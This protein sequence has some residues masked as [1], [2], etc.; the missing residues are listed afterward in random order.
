MSNK[1]QKGVAAVELA[2]ILPFLLILLAGII[3]FSLML[4]NMQVLTNGAREG[5]RVAVIPVRNET[6][7][8][9]AN[10]VKDYC[11]N[12]LIGFQNDKV[13]NVSIVGYGGATGSDLT[14]TAS[15]NYGFFIPGLFD[16]LGINKSNRIFN[17]N[18][19]ATMQ[20][21]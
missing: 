15:Y 9:I 16:F 19:K 12:K 18:G 1:S 21:L 5:A 10:I 17:I 20:F 14:V 6:E 2:V 7:E 8:E 3:E 4:Y 11:G 13:I